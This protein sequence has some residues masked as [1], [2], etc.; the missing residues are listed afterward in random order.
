[1]RKLDTKVSV[2]IVVEYNSSK[3][4]DRIL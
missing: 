3:K 1:V 4:K 2:I